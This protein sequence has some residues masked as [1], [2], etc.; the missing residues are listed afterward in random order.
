MICYLMLFAAL[1]LI[2]LQN[3]HLYTE[4]IMHGLYAKSRCAPSIWGGKGEK[5]RKVCVLHC[6]M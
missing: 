6:W 2:D 3:L 4:C 1:N 5:M